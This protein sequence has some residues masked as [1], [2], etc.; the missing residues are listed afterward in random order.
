MN[1]T[2]MRTKTLQIMR[3]YSNNGE[4][5]AESVNLDYL[6]SMNNFFDMAQKEIAQTK[7]INAVYE[8]SQYPI[9]SGLG[10]RYGFDMIRKTDD[11]VYM[12]LAGATAYCFSVD[13]TATVLIQENVSGTWV[14]LDTKT[15]T[16]KGSFTE[17][18]DVISASQPTNEIRV[19][20]T[21]DYA[22]NIKNRAM[23]T[24]PFETAEDVPSFSPYREYSMPTGFHKLNKVF[25]DVP[26]GQFKEY[27][28]YKF[29]PDR[30]IRIDYFAQGNFEVHYH[31]VPDTIP[32]DADNIA[33]GADYEFQIDAE[34]QE[35]IP[36]RAAYLALRDEPKID[37]STLL[38]EYYVGLN[39]L[40]PEDGQYNESIE[41]V[42]T[43]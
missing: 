5:N 35:L 42:Y 10:D 33:I 13:N 29:T 22:Y 16:T 23:F 36:L 3:E 19:L 1:V 38:N 11:D 8:F 30:K 2:E 43:M 41:A 15:N 18:K 4:I 14:T 9:S 26:T 27:T 17:Y 34:A 6:L 39:N 21:G 40:D 28:G 7:P 32:Y 37:L 24:D 20:F 12:I 31:K 25:A